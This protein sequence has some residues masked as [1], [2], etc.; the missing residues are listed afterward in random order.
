M[1]SGRLSALY[2][3]STAFVALLMGFAGVLF[4]FR[5]DGSLKV[6]QHLGYPLYFSTLIGMTRTLGSAAI[7]LPVPRG[8]REWAYAGLTFD[9][10]T[11][12]LSILFS[13]LPVLSIIQPLIVLLALMGSYLCWHMRVPSSAQPAL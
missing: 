3:V 9:I 7:L 5:L 13:G 8:V 11:T 10:A 4:L 2:W 12:I 1:N 6:I